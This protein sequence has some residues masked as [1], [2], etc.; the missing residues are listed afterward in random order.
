MSRLELEAALNPE[1]VEAVTHEGPAQLVLA[2]A[3]SGKTRVI[4]YRVAW[5]VEERGVDPSRIAAVTFTNK[6][7]AEMRER[8]EGL[9]GLYPLPAF[10][11]TF[12]RLALR[13]LRRYGPKVDL[14]NDFSILDGSDQLTIVKRSMKAAGVPDD[15]F[16]PQAVLGAISQAKNKLIGP[17]L[18]NREVDDFFGRKVAA[19]YQHYQAA[20]REA[21]AVDFDDMI[22]LSVELLRTQAPIRRRVQGQWRHVLVDEFQDTNHAQLALIEALVGTTGQLTAVGDED[23]GIYRWRGAELE[24]ILRFEHTFPGATIRKLERNY[25][26]TQNILDASGAVVARNEKRRGKELWTDSGAGDKILLYRARDEEDEARWIAGALSDLEPGLGWRRLAVLVRTNAQTRAVEDALLRRGVPYTLVAGVR[27]Y[28]RAEIKDLVAYLRL[29]RNPENPLAFERALNRPARGIGKTTQTKLSQLAASEGKS[30]WALLADERALRTVLAGRA[31]Q[32]LGRFRQLID[33]LR[34]EAEILPLPALLRQV[35]DATGY[36]EQFDTEDEADRARVENIEELVSAAQELT[37][38]EGYSGEEDVLGAF[39]DQASLASDTDSLGGGGVSLMTLHAAKGLEFGAVVVSGLEEGLLPHFNSAADADSL[40]EERRL[41]Y[42]G[43]TRAE[44][45]LVLTT[46]RRRRVAG[47]WQDQEESRFLAEVPG[48]LLRVEHSPELFASRHEPA[49]RWGESLDRRRGR[50]REDVMRFFGRAAE[51]VSQE[52]AEEPPTAAQAR[53]FEPSTPAG[54]RLKRGSRVRH[55]KLGLGKVLSIEGQGDDAKL[56]VFFDGIGRRKL[57]A[58]YA[59]L[60]V[61]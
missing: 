49:P 42:V 13:L 8:I 23:Q 12:H 43:M 1:Q 19:V 22:R 45:R 16:R 44:E 52:P 18:Y 20:L 53:L 21:A 55:G 41:F 27:F 34:R 9:L 17:A 6:A 37:E 36:L 29:L 14:P 11:G 25:R 58:K 46:C 54:G 32:A 7:A 35:L 33:D 39:L 31:I 4:T 48:D 38:K 59:Q 61:I 51:D 50:S 60:D 2:G 26:S 28:E 15:A 3:G 24:N 30:R 5:L 57:I 10:V 40:E 56:V 47:K